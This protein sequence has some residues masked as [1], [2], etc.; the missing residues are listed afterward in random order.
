M[1]DFNFDNAVEDA[2]L[3]ENFVDAWKQLHTDTE[4]SFT[5]KATRKYPAARLDRF[6]ISKQTKQWRATK[7]E[8]I[9]REP[10]PLYQG[11]NARQLAFEDE[12]VTPSDHFGLYVEIEYIANI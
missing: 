3:E 5:M 12:V 6:C 1:G 4:E 10:L 11:A 9:G 2:Y 7:I 8:R